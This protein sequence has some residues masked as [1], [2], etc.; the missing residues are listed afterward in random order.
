MPVGF[1]VVVQEFMVS[2]T[3][4]EGPMM[5]AEPGQQANRVMQINRRSIGTGRKSAEEFIIILPAREGP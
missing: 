1:R 5:V 2:S 3:T 4:T